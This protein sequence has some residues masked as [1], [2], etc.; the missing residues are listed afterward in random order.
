M[1]KIK[2]LKMNYEFKNVLSKGRYYIGNQIIIYSLKNNYKYNRIGIAISSKICN[3]VKRNHIKRL[4]RASYQN[5]KTSNY[6][7][8]D[9]VVMWNKKCNIKNASFCIIK[10]DM[11]EGF[12]KLKIIE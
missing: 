12:N 7:S 5:I 8:V 9:I 10:E 1:K 6:K 11:I 4:I 3:A 2:T